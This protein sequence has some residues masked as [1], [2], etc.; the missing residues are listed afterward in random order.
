MRLPESSANK[1]HAA[2]V[3]KSLL[4]KPV[5]DDVIK[6]LEDARPVNWNLILTQQFQIEKGGHHEAE[7]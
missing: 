2:L 3:S 5:I 4:E 1:L 6:S 7:S